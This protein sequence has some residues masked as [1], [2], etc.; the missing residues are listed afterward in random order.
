MTWFRLT[1]KHFTVMTH[2][3]QGVSNHR[4]LDYF[5]WNLFRLTKNQSC[6]Q[7]V[8]CQ[9]NPSVTDEN[10]H[11]LPV[12]RKVCP[13]HNIFMIEEPEIDI[14]RQCSIRYDRSGSI[15]IKSK[16]SASLVIFIMRNVVTASV[17]WSIR[18][19]VATQQYILVILC[20]AL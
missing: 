5:F 7:L 18:P 15:S 13:Y 11:K 2:E 16:G 9:S 19:N 3:R 14:S 6:V 20:G 8:Y 1:K 10:P 12:R 17:V 4:Q